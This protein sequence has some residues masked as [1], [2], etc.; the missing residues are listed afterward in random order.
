MVSKSAGVGLPANFEKLSLP[1][2][3]FLLHP[4]ILVLVVRLLLLH[5]LG[6]FL[7][8]EAGYYLCQVTDI[9]VSRERTFLMTDGGLHHHLSNSGNFGQVIRKNYPVVLADKLEADD[10]ETVEIAGPLCTPLDIVAAS[11]DLPVAELGDYIAVLQ[12][13]AYGATAS[14]QGFLSHP[15]V[16]EILL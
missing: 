1:T 2:V 11:I 9:K 13:G 12:S 6:R 15:E 16:K 10:L 14:P 4:N 8:G 7:V 3:H 5:E